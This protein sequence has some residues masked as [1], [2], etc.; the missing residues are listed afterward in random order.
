LLRTA[1]KLVA[2]VMLRAQLPSRFNADRRRRWTLPSQRALAP[3]AAATA[4]S[5]CWTG[6]SRTPQRS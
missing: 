2:C 3:A 5:C 6:G 1:T 4:P